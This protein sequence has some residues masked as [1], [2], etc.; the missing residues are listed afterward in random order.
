MSSV[1]SDIDGDNLTYTIVSNP[2]NGTLSEANGS[3][4]IILQMRVLKE[5]IHTFKVNDGSSDSNTS[6]ITLTVTAPTKHLELN[7]ND[8]RVEFD[9]DWSTFDG[10]TTNTSGEGVG[11]ILLLCQFGST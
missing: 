6:T 8:T 2:S 10:Y 7:G 9:V 4:I 3:N 5:L 1:A 11:L